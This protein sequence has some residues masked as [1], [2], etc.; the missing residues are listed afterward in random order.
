MNDNANESNLN[1][2]LLAI[3]KELRNCF[4][5]YSCVV[6]MFTIRVYLNLLFFTY[7]F[8]ELVVFLFYKEKYGPE[9]LRIRKF[10][11][12]V[13]NYVPQIEE[14]H[15][16]ETVFLHMK[17]ISPKY[18]TLNTPCDLKPQYRGFLLFS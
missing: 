2:I 18:L 16:D 7:Y 17:I 8:W 13:D 4:T 1:A 9:K 6:S 14:T 3:L 12:A 11:Y 10:I 15:F 5:H